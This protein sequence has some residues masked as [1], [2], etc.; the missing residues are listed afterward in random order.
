M[1]RI[2]GF[3]AATLKYMMKA[4]PCDGGDPFET[5]DWTI[6]RTRQAPQMERKDMHPRFDRESL[7]VSW[8]GYF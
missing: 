5:Q 4:S 7:P 1:E 2:E 8:L 6:G 3:R